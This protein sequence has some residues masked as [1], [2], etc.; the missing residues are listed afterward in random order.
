LRRDKSGQRFEKWIYRVAVEALLFRF[1]SAESESCARREDNLCFV[2]SWLNFRNR[3]KMD[4]NMDLTRIE[5]Q[6]VMDHA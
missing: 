1:G 2:G 6:R 3:P 4:V 5:L